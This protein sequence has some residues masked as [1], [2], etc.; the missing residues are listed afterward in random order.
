MVAGLGRIRQRWDDLFTAIGRNLRALDEM[1]AFKD[2]F[3]TKFKDYLGATYDVMQNKSMIPWL[4]YRPT[5]EVIKETKKIFQDTMIIY[6]ANRDAGK[7]LSDL[8]A[9]QAIERVLDTAE[10]PK[11]MRMD[12]P[13]DPYFAI[14]EFMAQDPKFFASKSVYDDVVA[15]MG[16]EVDRLLTLHNLLK[17]LDRLLKNS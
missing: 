12:K 10:L 17:N 13:S 8:E 14:P 15:G 6:P 9:E 4:R 5:E 1:K 2:A 3:G 11:G 7:T 16:E